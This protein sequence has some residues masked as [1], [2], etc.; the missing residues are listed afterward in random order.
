M[1]SV[2]TSTRAFQGRVAIVTG[3]LGVIGLAITRAL[4]QSGARLVLVDLPGSM[5]DERQAAV[6]A[7]CHA[8]GSPQALLLHGDVAN[9]SQVDAVMDA[10]MVHAG[11][12]DVLVNVAGAMMYKSLET[13]TPRDWQRML[14]V[15]LLG[16]VYFTRRALQVMPR[17]SSIV[18]IASVHALQTSSL[19]AAYAA[20]KAALLSL[21]RSTAI[22]GKSKGIRANAIVPG[23][24]D[25][26]MLWSNP[27]VASGAESIPADMVGRPE[28][29]AAATMFL[30]SPGA[31]FITGAALQVDGGR[32]ASL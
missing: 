11:R 22:E 18:N 4:A 5:T 19:V 9:A 20:A 16:A 6:L 21:T 28:D 12:V 2:D 32:V 15:N 26:P 10:A 30:A 1:V 31:E 27:N 25:T 23:A 7:E 14:G 17:G 24:I 3:G 13:L 29:V 8:L